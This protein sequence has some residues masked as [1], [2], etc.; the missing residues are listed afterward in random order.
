MRNP[1]RIYVLALLLFVPILFGAGQL[2]HAQPATVPMEGEPIVSMGQPKKWPPY[3]GLMFD[4]ARRTDEVGG[5]LLAGVYRD[6]MNP[7]LGAL[8]LVGEGYVTTT[9][10]YDGGARLMGAARFFALQAG[11]DYSIR[12]NEVDFLL[13]FTLGLRRGGVVGG[14]SYFR[15]DYYPGRNHSFSLGLQIPIFQ[16]YMGK[17]RPHEPHVELPNAPEPVV[18]TYEPGPELRDALAN[19]EHAA[20][21]ISRF[22]TPF[23]DQDGGN[24]EKHRQAFLDALSVYKEHINTR[25]ALYP[26]GHTFEAEI[27]M[28]HRELDRAYA[29]AAGG[30]GRSEESLAFGAR[31]ALGART[32]AREEMILPYNRLLGQR[33]KNDSLHGYEQACTTVFT[34]YI[35]ATPAIEP[36]YRPA[37]AYVFDSMLRYYEANR[38]A[39]RQR[40]G[41]SRLVWLPLHWTLKP[42]EVDSHEELDAVI[43]A[44]LQQEFSDGNDIHYVINEQFTTELARMIHEAEDYHVLWIHDYDGK[45]HAGNPDLIGYRMT[46]EAYLQALIKA[47]KNYD[48]TWR[49]PTYMIFLDQFYYEATE[50]R[51]WLELLEDPLHHEVKLPEEY[52][53]WSDKLRQA[54]EE[55]RQAV[56]QSE[57]LQAGKRTHGKE[58]LEN[59]IKVHVSIT[60]PTDLTFRSRHL[61]TGM[62]FVPD[63]LMRDHRKITFYDV[64]EIFP[65]K[66]EAMYTG[67]G[68]GE[69]YTGPTWDDRA[70]LASGPFLVTL[71]D[72][73]RELLLSQGYSERDI[74]LPLRP[75]PK[76]SNYDEQLE[77]L[78]AQGWNATAL[79]A[80]NQTGYADK[81]ANVIKATLY[82]L[83][84]P[85]SHF[86]MPDS[87]W[88]SFLWGGLVTG[89][90]LR[91]CWVFPVA[92]AK[93]NAPAAAAPLLSRSSELLARLVTMQSELHD[94]ISSAGGRLRVGIYAMDVDVDDVVGRA[95]IFKEKVMNDPFFRE[96]FPF[97]PEVY[98]M[99]AGMDSVHIANGYEPMYLSEDAAKRLPKL[100]MKAQFFASNE[101][102]ETLIPLPGWKQLI[103]DYSMVRA[104]QRMHKEDGLGVKEMRSFL[105]ES[106]L[107][108]VEEWREAVTPEVARKIM[109]YLTIGS[110]N[111]N[112]RSSIMDG[113]VTVLIARLRAMAAYLDLVGVLMETTWVDT[114]EELEELLPHQSGKLRWVGRYLRNAF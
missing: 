13:S 71:K 38:K 14:G 26:D 104:K 102:L 11:A 54:Q 20:D 44:A 35:E 111:Q 81:R 113:E 30:D 9:N 32:V 114:E 27:E 110:Q 93:G 70:V 57:R 97:A 45:N 74:P 109:F 50:G 12:E 107:G 49:I 51:F 37:I 6:L 36:Q 41:D 91:G 73:A 25:G 98:D 16:P 100:H 18:P 28:Y 31:L 80:H 3:L 46:L 92:P 78:R 40:W 8:A 1:P 42:E 63:L 69:Q 101:A 53:E 103:R 22:T 76:P 4:S 33:K 79:Q 56:E 72:A 59:K 60:N 66:G 99:V 105:S 108:L 67:M 39:L 87:I 90:S 86:Y 88:N 52:A 17:T 10:D 47:V 15:A 7:N 65:G 83:M 62:W 64:T 95:Q 23:F 48:T 77:A 94:E 89:A 21:W 58:W 84:P 34:R 29:I 43:E 106:A 112:Y 2:A 82:N 85:G 5:Q 24:D 68:V 19:V 75:L 96:V 61:V 55:L